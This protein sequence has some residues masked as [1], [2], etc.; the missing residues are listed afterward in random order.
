MKTFTDESGAIW[1]ATALEEDTPRHHT[2]WYLVIE[3][4]DGAVFPAPE[5]RWQTRATA[6]RTL[7]TM[8]DF[9]LRRRLHVGRERALLEHGASPVDGADPESHRERTNANAG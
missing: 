7:R 3:G 4:A 5:V 9:E 8:S 1:V 6:E 2:R